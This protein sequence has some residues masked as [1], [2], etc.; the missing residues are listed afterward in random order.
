MRD[1]GAEGPAGRQSSMGF[2]ALPAG[3]DV[4]SDGTEKAVLAF[5]PDVFDGD[6]FPAP[7]M[8]TIYVTKGRR[9]R[10]PGRQARPDDPWYVTLFLE[11]EVSG[12]EQ[13]YDDRAAAETAACDI[14]RAFADGDIDYRALYQVP[15]D[16]YFDELDRLTGRE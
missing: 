13:S 7:C 11:P 15:R 6:A 1:R 2:D 14:A 5:R 12:E 8:P 9:R 3:W 10:Q 4:W 16:A